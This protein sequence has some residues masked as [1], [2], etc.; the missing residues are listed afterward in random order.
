MRFTVLSLLAILSLSRPFYISCPQDGAQMLF[1]RQ[2]GEGSHA[3]CWYS[4]M[5]Y[6]SGPNGVPKQVKHEAYVNCTDN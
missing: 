5:T 3:V 1:E 2:V 6:E 4:H